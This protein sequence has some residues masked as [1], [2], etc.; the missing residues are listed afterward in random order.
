[1]DWFLN[2]S[3]FSTKLGQEGSCSDPESFR[4]LGPELLTDTSFSST[5][6]VAANEIFKVSEVNSVLLMMG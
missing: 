1:M 2:A 5:L 4:P 3:F 6:H